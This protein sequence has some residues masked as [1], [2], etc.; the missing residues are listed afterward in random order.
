M[1]PLRWGIASCGKISTDMAAAILALPPTEHKL[2]ACA[3]RNS[4]SAADE[5]AKKYNIPIAYDSYEKLAK[6]ADID[7]VYIG[8]IHPTHVSIGELMVTNG[9]HV[10]IEK[11]IGMNEKEAE[12]IYALAK[13]HKRFCMEALWSRFLPTYG[14][15]IRE[16]RLQE[17]DSSLGQALNI[18]GSFGF[19]I[20]EVDR[21]S[22]KALGGGVTLDLGIYPFHV[23]FCVFG[24]KNIKDIVVR[25]HLNKE[26]CDT[27]V[28]VIVRYEPTSKGGVPR[29]ANLTYSGHLE[30]PNYV[31]ISGTKGTITLTNPFWHTRKLLIPNDGQIEYKFPDTVEC[32]YGNGPGFTYQ[33]QE[34]KR[35][36]DKGLL[37][38]ERWS[39]EE[40]L[41]IHRVL[42]EVRRQMVVVYPQDQQ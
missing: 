12:R 18:V 27:S 31:T 42:D 29:T 34:V 25:G 16:C 17:E 23:A 5:F 20:A 3:T 21:I 2:L 14:H 11:P 35:C 30:L 26:G 32:H 4:Q 28:S 8:S 37:E 15:L 19:P 7:V 1:G 9:K 24:Y 39:H 33:V 6:N 36:I 38:S 22:E 40:S 10:L 13:K 41:A